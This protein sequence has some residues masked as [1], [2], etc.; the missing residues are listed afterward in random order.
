MNKLSSYKHYQIQQT[1]DSMQSIAFKLYQDMSMWRTLVN[2]NHLRYPYLVKTP[3]EKLNDPEHLLTWGD[4]LLLPNDEETLTKAENNKLIESNTP[5]NQPAYYDDTLGMDLSLDISTDATQSEQ[6]GVLT[7]N[8]YTF[9]RAIGEDNLKQSL[10]LRIL[11][12]RGTLLM[13]PRYGSQ[14]PNMIGKPM[15]SKLLADCARELKRTIMTDTRVYKCKITRSLL[16]YN[17]IFLDASVTPISYNTA[18]DI[19]IYRSE[20]G[21]ISIR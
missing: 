20:S 8:G 9:K 2:L 14:L 18:F 5:Y 11:T 1:D 13:H 15:N 21:Q 19:F 12:R 17:Q 16:S 6:I 4:D 7:T 3:Q 10:M